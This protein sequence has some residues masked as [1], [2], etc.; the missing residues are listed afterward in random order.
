MDEWHRAHRSSTF[1][2][3]GAQEHR[4]GG[5]WGRGTCSGPHRRVSCGEAV[6]RQGSV[7]VVKG[8]RWGGALVWE[9]RRGELV[10]GL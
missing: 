3:S 10:R 4:P 6:G 5:K 1:G 2:R 8:A 9:R 7:V